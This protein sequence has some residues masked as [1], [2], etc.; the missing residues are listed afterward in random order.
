MIS[1]IK[2]ETDLLS[3]TEILNKTGNPTVATQILDG[4]YQEPDICR[5]NMASSPDKEGNREE[6]TFEGYDKWKDEV[7]YKG[8]NRW[9]N[10]MNRENWNRL[11]SWESVLHAAIEAEE[12]RRE[13]E[14]SNWDGDETDK[15][16]C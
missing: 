16:P 10:E 7:L 14:L 9:S 1:L 8:K 11:D 5:F 15:I 13:E 3:L 2:I 6:Y 12:K 4:S